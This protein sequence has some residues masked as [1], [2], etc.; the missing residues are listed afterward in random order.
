[1]AQ[2]QVST[3]NAI[4]SIL[5]EFLVQASLSRPFEQCEW[6]LSTF[7]ALLVDVQLTRPFAESLFFAL[8]VHKPDA[9]KKVVSSY[10]HQRR[11]GL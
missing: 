4:N 2:Q 7:D 8:H 3:A 5:C 9:W 6:R 10:S 1:M 11:S